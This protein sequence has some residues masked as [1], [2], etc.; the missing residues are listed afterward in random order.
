MKQETELS[1]KHFYFQ[2]IM[3]SF[4]ELSYM[5]SSVQLL[6]LREEIKILQREKNCIEEKISL[7]MKQENELSAKNL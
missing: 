5:E 3:E 1:A 4:Y 6:N 7:K 2:L